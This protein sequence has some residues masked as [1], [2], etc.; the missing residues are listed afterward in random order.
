MSITTDMMLQSR[1]VD[2]NL[3]G[4]CVLCAPFRHMLPGHGL[5]G[6]FNKQRPHQPSALP[7]IVQ[8]GEG[9]IRGSVGGCLADPS[10]PP[11]TSHV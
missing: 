6:L 9:C 5:M 7:V 11:P 4:V 10:P 3:L 2:E 8:S 1:D